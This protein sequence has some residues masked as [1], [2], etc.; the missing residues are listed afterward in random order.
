MFGFGASLLGRALGA[1]N[2]LNKAKGLGGAVNTGLKLADNVSTA[3]ALPYLGYQ[4]TQLPGNM[5]EGIIAGKPNDPDKISGFKFNPIQQGVFGLTNTLGM[6]NITEE[7]VE[8]KFLDRKRKELA[9][10]NRLI[11][12]RLTLLNQLPSS[13][14]LKQDLTG[15]AYLSKTK[16]EAQE[17]LDFKQAKR[18]ALEKGIPT[19]GM[20]N[21]TQVIQAINDDPD[22]L[23]SQAARRRENERRDRTDSIQARI[24]SN[25]LALAGLEAKSAQA[26]RTQQ[27]QLMQLGNQDRRF[28]RESRR[29]ER[30]DQQQLYTMLLKSLGNM[31]F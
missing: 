12:E 17:I 13:I 29:D 26:D 30:A 19:I 15:E 21:A 25:N 20:T 14:D 22:S 2:K 7:S 27:I 8:K 5:E 16:D 28:E 31:R 24:D 23:K 11:S 6:T 3:V 18:V 4:A 9:A 10:N 1:A